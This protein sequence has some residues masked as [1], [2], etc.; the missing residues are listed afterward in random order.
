MSY[1]LLIAR[2]ARADENRVALTPQDCRQ[3]LD[4]FPGLSISLEPDA[5]RCYSA[6]EYEEAGVPSSAD[7]NEADLILG[8]KEPDPEL[9]L[10]AKT[11]A[12]FSHT[13]KEQSH[14][15]SLVRA[16]RAKRIKLLDYEYL[17]DSE[18]KRLAA[19]G[20]SAGLVGAYLSLALLGQKWQSW[21]LPTGKAVPDYATMVVALNNLKDLRTRIL[22]SGDGRVAQGAARVLAQAGLAQMSE[23]EWRSQPEQPGYCL[24][25]VCDYVARLD[26]GKFSAE[27]FYQRPED[28]RSNAGVYLQSADCYLACH[29]WHPRAPLM[30]SLG[31][32]R[33]WKQRPAVIGDISC[34]IPGSVP[35]TIRASSLTEPYYHLNWQSG[36]EEPLHSAENL[37]VMAVDNLPN[38]L[39]R[40]ASAEFSAALARE[41]IPYLLTQ[42]DG[43]IARMTLETSD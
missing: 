1:H 14:N 13:A 23:L 41:F 30:F 39:A 15:Q 7:P 8:V 42:D 37:S 9:L 12:C 3:L 19:F 11:Y 20:T 4:A 43:R 36:A 38:A 18:G 32:A 34:D 21:Q 26:A 10:A 33:T 24:L 31:E 28:F 35:T 29:Y 2:E 17:T 5:K 22:V 16:L 25:S 27:D 6:Q 40:E